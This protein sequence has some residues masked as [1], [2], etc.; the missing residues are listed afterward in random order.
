MLGIDA[1]IRRFVRVV[2]LATFCIGGT[3]QATWPQVPPPPGTPP[4]GTPQIS[5]P[6]G[7]T[8][9]QPGGQ[10][11]PS[12][13]IAKPI[14]DGT[15]A[16]QIV[17]DFSKDRRLLMCRGG[18]E[19]PL[20]GSASVRHGSIVGFR[21]ANVNKFLYTVTLKA[22][23]VV[24]FQDVPDTFSSA[25]LPKEKPEKGGSQANAIGKEKDDYSK[26]LETFRNVERTLLDI[27]TLDD[28]ITAL[29]SRQRLSPQEIADIQNIATALAAEAL[30]PFSSPKTQ[31]QI[32][33]ELAKNSGLISMSK[34]RAVKFLT[35]AYEALRNAYNA[36]LPKITDEGVKTQVKSEFDK[37]TKDYERIITAD[38][39]A[40]PGQPSELSKEFNNAAAVYESVRSGSAFDAITS[41]RAAGDALK[42]SYEIKPKKSGD[43]GLETLSDDVTVQVY[44]GFHIN[45]STG[46]FASQLTDLNAGTITQNN[47][48]VVV[49]KGS[50]KVQFPLGA[51][52]HI[53]WREHPV[54][55][56]F[57]P[58]LSVGA[59]TS[60]KQTQF[61]VGGSLLM[62]NDRRFIVTIGR[63][64]GPAKR[65]APGV[66][67]GQALPAGLTESTFTKNT[68]AW[69]LGLTF[70]LK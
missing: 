14:C 7:Q 26:A 13:F 28:S 21:V 37:A 16:S 43:A 39:A 38:T 70:N 55:N 54:M 35:D 12:I 6:P 46:I 66:V 1:G 49:D 64:F 11:S 5:P 62:G 44:G 56:L 63:A 69:V 48:T 29:A 58:A 3:Q 68:D 15:T 41:I 18:K 36:Y 51:L 8:G 24:L 32:E 31:R 61:I 2:T 10:P 57:Q 19:F 60:G 67:L 17:F 4:Q 40:T 42:F 25:L 50:D 53:Y 30:T 9:G 47:Q 52:T 23:R 33:E 45:F 20:T 34:N 59:A 27:A 22:E 65:L